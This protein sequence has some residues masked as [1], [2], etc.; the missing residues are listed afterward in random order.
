MNTLQI[1]HCNYVRP[2][3]RW[4]SNYIFSWYHWVLEKSGCAHK[5]ESKSL[6]IKPLT[7][8]EKQILREKRLSILQKR[9]Q[10]AITVHTDVS[11]E[12]KPLYKKPPLIRKHS[13]SGPTEF[14][15]KRWRQRYLSITQS[16]KKKNIGDEYGSAIIDITRKIP[17]TLISD[18]KSDSDVSSDE[19]IVNT[20]IS[21]LHP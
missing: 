8:E 2:L 18:E 14:Q 15:K 12:E 16:I 11:Y 13:E 5:E 7:E 10:K 4:S 6:P 19:S 21:D 1:L 9:L 17:T 20:E 3:Y